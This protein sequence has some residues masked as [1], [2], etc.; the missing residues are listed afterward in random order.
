MYICIYLNGGQAAGGGQPLA[1]GGW[2]AASGTPRAD[3]RDG[4]GHSAGGRLS[5]GQAANSVR[6]D[7]EGAGVRV[8]ELMETYENMMKRNPRK[9]DK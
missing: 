1:S 9:Q 8:G 7:G 4:C 5:C 2:R 6:A 3:G